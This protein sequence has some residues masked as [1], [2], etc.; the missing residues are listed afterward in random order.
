MRR[1]E[2][3]KSLFDRGLG[4]SCIENYLLYILDYLKVDY[5]FLYAKSYIPISDVI[6]SLYIN[7]NS[8]AYFDGIPRLQNTAS[9]WELVRLSQETDL[10]SILTNDF[11]SCI[12]V[13]PQFIRERYTRELWR[14]DHFIMLCEDMDNNFLLLNDNPRD[15]IEL[16]RIQLNEVFS[17]NAICF[18]VLTCNDVENLKSKSLK[19]FIS[20]IAL[21]QLT[22]SVFV[23]DL[24][25]ARDITGIIRITRKRTEEYCSIFFNTEF[26]SEYLNQID[27]L[28][29]MFEYMRIRNRVDHIK[30]NQLLSELQVEDSKIFSL[31]N[32][33]VGVML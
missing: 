33:K 28:Y 10:E 2:A 13:T 30:V 18:E 14:D 15:L 19:E 29:V 17:K 1:I 25:A 31:I 12:R 20:S 6:Q 9:E 23:D 3:N 8:F 4:L 24:E 21:S 7:K 32:Q 27:K 26:M 16:D 22:S 5:R 11:Y